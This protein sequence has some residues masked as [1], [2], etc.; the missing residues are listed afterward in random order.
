[1]APGGGW[2][3]GQ[4]ASTRVREEQ[5]GP[6]GPIAAACFAV[7]L[8]AVSQ[9][10]AEAVS[11]TSDRWVVRGDETRVEQHLGR[12]SLYLKGATVWLK[13]VE[14]LDGTIDFDISVTGERGFMG[15][16]WRLQDDNDYEEFY[17]RPHMSGNPDA[18]QYTPV[19]NGVAAWQLYHGEGYSA[20]VQYRMNEWVHVRIVVSG[21]QGEVY[22]D[23]DKPVL[24][25][26]EMK[27]PVRPGRI[28][29]VSSG[30]AEAHFANFAYSLEEKPLL[31]SGPPSSPRPETAEG[32]I[33]TWSVSSA[34]DESTLDAKY[35]LTDADLRGLAWEQAEAE[36]T[37]LVNLAAVRAFG[38]KADTVF[39]RV[40]LRSTRVQ[41]KRVSFGYSDRAK[42]WFNGRLIFG[43]TTVYQSRDYRYL[44]T[45]GLFE[46]ISLPLRKGDTE[47]WFA[48]SESFGGWGILARLE[49]EQ[50]V[51][52]SAA[53]APTLTVPPAP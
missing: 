10:A 9:A 1:M 32:T 49:D 46:D 45:I 15:A 8:C 29:L 41:V 13:D 2:S 11:F 51:S 21:S 22:V 35:V 37:G 6:L 18:T 39:A 26:R 30:P 16:L 28:G 3:A 20:P 47:L 17:I 19:F 4:S 27:R 44:G 50:G 40:T 33:R 12:E 36:P 43:G 48:V 7:T 52:V 38:E 5:R 25:I 14:F 42:V 23:S 24:F 53:G 31:K 34:F